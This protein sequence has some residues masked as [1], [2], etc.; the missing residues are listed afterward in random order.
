M[1]IAAPVPALAVISC[2]KGLS[3]VRYGGVTKAISGAS[4]YSCHLHRE[5]SYG[6]VFPIFKD[7]V[8]LDTI[9]HTDSFDVHDSLGVFEFHYV[10]NN[11]LEF[12]AE[13]ISHINVNE[14]SGIRSSVICEVATAVRRP[15]L[16]S[17]NVYSNHSVFGNV[18]FHLDC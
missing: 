10:R 3:C 5:Y 11:H 17:Q 16:S 7:N 1:A 15:S 8:R 18:S 12:F 2:T 4:G 14:T 6:H 13:E 9:V